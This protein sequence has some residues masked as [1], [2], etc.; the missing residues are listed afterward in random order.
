MSKPR[1][2][3]E[4]EL[5]GSKTY[6][7]GVPCKRGGIA[8]RRLNG[9]CL[10]EACLSFVKMLKDEYY[11]KN[12][13][14]N[15]EWRERHPEKMAEYKKAWSEKNKEKAKHNLKKWKSANKHK[16]LAD[17][18][19]RR[20]QQ[21]NATPIWYG[22]LDDFVFQ[23]AALLAK[24]RHYSTGIK[25]HVDHMIPLMA[26]QA[27]GLH[28]ASNIQVIPETLNCVKRNTMTFTEPFEWVKAL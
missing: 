25:W 21:I 6:F 2:R 28:C 19:R 27:K 3:K 22:E 12:S 24:L 26:K 14:K 13:H 9:D 16:V 4:A 15:A 7:T 11:K 17:F 23:E 20:A 1:N 10:C 8:D 18:H 5:Q